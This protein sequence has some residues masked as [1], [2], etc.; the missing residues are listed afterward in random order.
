MSAGFIPVTHKSDDILALTDALP[1]TSFGL[2]MTALAALVVLILQQTP[3]ETCLD[4]G[5]CVWNNASCRAQT[6]LP[7]KEAF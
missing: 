2:T 7:E 3:E 4:H 6:F 1:D 5:S